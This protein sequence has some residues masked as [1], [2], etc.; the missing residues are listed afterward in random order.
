MT[1]SFLRLGNPSFFFCRSVPVFLS[2][3]VRFSLK[4]TSNVTFSRS[5]SHSFSKTLERNS[6]PDIKNANEVEHR[7]ISRFKKGNAPKQSLRRLPRSLIAD[8]PLQSCTTVSTAENY[9]L[10]QVMEILYNQGFRSA[11]VL[12]PDEVV[13]MEYPYHPGKKADIFIL[14]N[15][16]L[17]AWGMNE[18]EVAEKILPLLKPAE[19]RSYH[20]YESEDMDFIEN[21]VDESALTTNS[22]SN[23]NGN[24]IK[25]QHKSTMDGDTIII[26]GDSE[27]QRLLEKAAFSNGLARSTKLAAL[28]L[29]LE[30]YIKSTIETTDRLATGKNVNLGH[31]EILKR[32][33]QLLRLRGHLNLY[34]ELIET[35]D[36]YWSEPDMERLYRLI[37]VNLDIAPRIA[38]LN[39]KL[40]YASEF[41]GILKSHVVEEQ[42]SRLE[43]MIVILICIE[44]AFEIGHFA[45]RYLNK[46]EDSRL[47]S[48]FVKEN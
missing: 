39:K 5:L 9:S 10:P 2:N 33:G 6:I 22:G 25:N 19:I 43:W 27:Q 16:S 44:V 11:S 31:S 8:Q 29:S 40:D 23:S 7:V 34:S 4:A 14:A 37:S 47:T 36:L 17:I 18:V 32:T 26:E 41:V 21:I 15:G 35:P 12:L 30:K 20:N 42:S 46:S 3:S 48:I 24:G 45:E 13:H 38:I 28:E 1:V